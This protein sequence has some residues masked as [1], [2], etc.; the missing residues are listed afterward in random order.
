LQACL[1][2][3]IDSAARIRNALENAVRN[4][5]KFDE[6]LWNYL[7]QIGYEDLYL[8]DTNDIAQNMLNNMQNKLEAEKDE[9][10]KIQIK[11]EI[12]SFERMIKRLESEQNKPSVQ[13]SSIQVSREYIR[14]NKLE[15]MYDE[16]IP[17]KRTKRQYGTT[18]PAIVRF[19]N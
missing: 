5:N 3:Q 18:S 17:I 2:Q 4:Y 16:T 9:K 7:I 19:V 8:P 11:N 6:D 10:K 13:E 12:E 1:G 14:N 15:G